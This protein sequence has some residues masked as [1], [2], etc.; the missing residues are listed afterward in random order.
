MGRSVAHPLTVGV[1]ANALN[2]ELLGDPDRLITSVSSLDAATDGELSFFAD[3]KHRAAAVRAA[4][5]I[6]LVRDAD[7]EITTGI[8]LIHPAP[9]LA[10]AQ[11]LDLLFPAD[12]LLA[13]V[14]SQAAVDS[15]ALIA[16]ARLD[17]FA[18]VGARSRIGAGS[19]IH[20]NATV[21]HDVE[22]GD[23]CTVH[24][25]AVIYPGVRLGHRCIVHSGAVIGADGFGFQ[26]GKNGW[27][28][29][30]QVGGVSIG[31]DVEIGSNTTIDRGAIDDTVIGN[32]V[33]ID[34][35][36][37]IAHNCHIGDNTAIAGCV[38]IAGS[39]RIGARCMLGG[40]AMVVGHLTICDDVVV[41]GGTLV[42]T[43]IDKPGQYTGVFPTTPHRDW[44]KIAATLR[45]S[46]K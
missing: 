28:K 31:D 17:A 35:Q 1:L 6:L 38:G 21:H 30:A 36:V 34:N 40:A 14:A 32:G 46:I 2:A 11:A 16:G 18:F 29:V 37:Q 22:I 24:S 27:R 19:H 43:S 20:P 7:R 45:R 42:A 25:S 15:T 9:H 4:T 41:S 26:P 12:P 8:R 39:T 13:G 33:K 5:S 23:D 44:M 3:R 10:F